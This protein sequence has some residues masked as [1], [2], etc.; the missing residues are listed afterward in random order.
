MIQSIPPS[1]VWKMEEHEIPFLIPAETQ[2]VVA[3]SLL[4]IRGFQNVGNC[5]YINCIIQVLL[6]NPVLVQYFL[7]DKHN[8]LRHN[9][10]VYYELFKLFQR[11][12][13]GTSST[14]CPTDFLYAYQRTSGEVIVYQQDAG[15]FFHK[16]IATSESCCGATDENH[17]IWKNFLK[18]TFYGTY[19]NTKICTKCNHTSTN[20]EN[21]TEVVMG[22]KKF[23]KFNVIMK[24][25]FTLF[26]A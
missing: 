16:F 17:T 18:E 11:C 1:V 12:C 5:C 2:S 15:E 19:L 22:A 23:Q 25:L 14:L 3:N 8:C 20:Q 13:H 10:C 21:F 9:N 7:L 6:H 26:L 24:H 4:G